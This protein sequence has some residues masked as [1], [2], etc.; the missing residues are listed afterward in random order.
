MINN[1][2]K[3]LTTLGHGLLS[4]ARDVKVMYNA[5]KTARKLLL[6]LPLDLLSSGTPFPKNF[7]D[8]PSR[9]TSASDLG[10]LPVKINCIEI[11]PG[12]LFGD[13]DN[14][15][16]FK[17]YAKHFTGTYFHACGTC[18]METPHPQKNNEDGDNYRNNSSDIHGSDE[19]TNNMAVVDSALRVRGTLNLR[20]ADASV[21]PW[22]PSGPTS[23][24]CMAVGEVKIFLTSHEHVDDH[25]YRT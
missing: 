21:F 6:G 18:A 19:C 15:D 8:R 9:G 4:D 25:A 10:L 3:L 17:I 16:N 2:C 24:T 1:I 23:A 5:M 13:T 14:E 11:L 7:P 22:I 20:V 12:P